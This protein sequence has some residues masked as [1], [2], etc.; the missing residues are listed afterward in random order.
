MALTTKTITIP[1]ATSITSLATN[2]RLDFA[3]VTVY[4]PET[5]SRTF[6]SVV[7]KVFTRDDATT[8]GKYIS[9]VLIGCKLGAAAFDDAT[10]VSSAFNQFS[11]FEH[12][13]TVFLRTDSALT[14]YFN[15][16]FGAGTSQTMQVGFKIQTCATINLSAFVEITYEYDDASV[17]TVTAMA[18]LPLD[19]AAG[20]LTNSLA[21]L[22]ASNNIPQLTGTGGVFEGLDS[23]TIRSLA[24]VVTGNEAPTATTDFQLGLQVDAESEVN[25][26]SHRQ[27]LQTATFYQYVWDRIDLDPSTS[28]TL[29]L[30]TTVTGRMNLASAVLVVQIEYNWSASSVAW[31]GL[32]LPLRSEQGLGAS[33]SSGDRS[34]LTAVFDVQDPTTIAMQQSG[35]HLQFVG[36]YRANWTISALIGGQS[37]RS[38]AQS[39]G[40]TF[41][42]TIAG[43][44]DLIQR[45]DSGGVQGSGHT[46]ARG[47]NEVKVGI[48]SSTSEPR[49]S[50]LAGMLYLNY[51]CGKAS[52]EGK[53]TRTVVHG[54][55][56]TTLQST[57]NMLTATGPTISLGLTSYALV[58]MGIELHYNAYVAGGG[59]G[60]HAE[61][62]SGEGIQD[63]WEPLLFSL[64][65]TGVSCHV[66]TRFVQSVGG[67]FYRWA[68]DVDT[69]RLNPS[70]A[71]TWRFQSAAN[72]SLM[73][74]M[75]YATI[76]GYAYT[77]A[78]TVTGL[79]API[80]GNAVDVHVAPGDDPTSPRIASATTDGSGNF[81]ATVYDNTRDVF[82]KVIQS[83]TKQG[84][85]A[86]GKA[87]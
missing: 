60:A 58:Q 14:T 85:S 54:I 57:A 13:G 76:H 3:A 80:D 65:H 18:Y 79:G 26:G 1:I 40:S 27:N 22:V 73:S 4:I 16:N 36:S 37:A 2:T 7:V 77:V 46:L 59:F 66:Y 6:R 12:K 29:N 56:S 17:T 11:E 8:S 81:S 28:H 87:A 48:W 84:I 10:V 51:R 71:R 82:A 35:V 64:F 38:Y 74:A 19:S 78:D 68:S 75:L 67:S 86:T 31:C 62:L 47:R 30:R 50:S 39:I 41:S 70:T 25:D 15:T 23:V 61:R 43:H 32:R 33:A 44:H 24:I 69:V 20:N 72:E 21:A 49:V 42:T 34:V 5:A 83:S 53:Q 45:I 52:S 63:G 9:N 55:V